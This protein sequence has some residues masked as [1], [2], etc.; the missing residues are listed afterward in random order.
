[1]LTGS[2]PCIP[3]IGIACRP[4][5][6]NLLRGTRQ[7]RP[8]SAPSAGRSVH[9]VVSKART[10]LNA[11]GEAAQVIGVNLD[12][13]HLREAEQARRESNSDIPISSAP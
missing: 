1:M 6:E 5:H 8:N 2:P 10:Y 7:G 9:W 11:A 3:T 13:T 12:V 4:Y